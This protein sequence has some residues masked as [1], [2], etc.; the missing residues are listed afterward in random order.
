MVNK[1]R[2]LAAHFFPSKLNVLIDGKPGYEAHLRFISYEPFI[3]EFEKVHGKKYDYSKVEYKNAHSKVNIICKEHGEFQQ[4]P[5]SHKKGTKCPECSNNLKYD[6]KR[7]IKRSK[8]L[9]PEI[10]S[11][12]FLLHL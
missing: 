1:E 9:Y 2:S 3:N 4:D 8:E 10:F 11:Y 12:L 6:T 5:H 7:F